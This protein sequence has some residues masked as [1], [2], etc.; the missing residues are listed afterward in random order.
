[1]SNYFHFRSQELLL[2]LAQVK[3]FITKHNPTIGVLTEEIIRQFLS[4]HLPDVVTVAEGFISDENGNLSKQ[5]DI[6]VYDSH[7]YAPYYQVNNIVVVPAAA[8]LAIIEVKTTISKQ[9]FHSVIDYFS[10]FDYIE[11]AKKYLFIYNSQS[12]SHIGRY[13]KNYKHIGEYQE[14][15]HDTYQYLPDVIAG[16]NESYYLKKSAVITDRDM[17]GYMS[18]FYNDMKGTEISALQHFYISLRDI[19]DEYIDKTY[20]NRK[21]KAKKDFEMKSTGVTGFGLFDV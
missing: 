2:K 19:V 10:S 1:M 12:I 4:D 17:Y 11:N 5:C 14:F 7:S 8:V 20:K 21:S 6:I 9:I 13:F 18:Y 16:L 15:D 3:H